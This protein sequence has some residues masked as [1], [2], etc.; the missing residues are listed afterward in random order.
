M[1]DWY[2]KED[3]LTEYD[4]CISD[5]KHG[6]CNGEGYGCG[7][8]LCSGDEDGAGYGCGEGFGTGEESGEDHI[9]GPDSSS[10]EGFG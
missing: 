2:L 3:N 7:A 5:N 4:F 1:N 10:G 8:V 6:L 9:S